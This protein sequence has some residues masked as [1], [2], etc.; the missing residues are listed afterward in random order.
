M[1]GARDLARLVH[2]LLEALV[3]HRQALL[4]QQLLGQLVW[5]AVGVVEL[6]RLLRRHP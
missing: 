2:Q 5:E 1:A 3:V 4:G 6:E